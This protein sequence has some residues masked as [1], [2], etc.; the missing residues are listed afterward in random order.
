MSKTIAIVEDEADIRANYAELFQRQ[1]YRVRTY[2]NRR[3]VLESFATQ[4]PDLAILDIG[5]GDEIDGGFELCRELRSAA[6]AHHLSQR[7]GQ[8]HRRGFRSP[9]RRR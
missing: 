7:Q 3:E 6:P 2:A 5:L 4:L 9:S 8:R 1:G